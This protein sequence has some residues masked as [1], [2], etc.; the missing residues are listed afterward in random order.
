M[1][2]QP[3][4]LPAEVLYDEMLTAEEASPSE[5]TTSEPA[6]AP[7]HVDTAPAPQEALTLAQIAATPTHTNC[8]FARRELER[9]GSQLELVR[10]ALAC[11]L[12]NKQQQS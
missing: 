7:L 1:S 10:L 6:P 12:R 5:R 11:R 2:T 8:D 4:P 3:P 9:L